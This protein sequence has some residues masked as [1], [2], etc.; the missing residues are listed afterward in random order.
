MSLKDKIKKNRW[1]MLFPRIFKAFRVYGFFIPLSKKIFEFGFFSKET[2]SFTYNLTAF[3]EKYII[4]S[5]ALV[6][7]KSVDEIETYFNEIKDDK[8]IQKYILDK[9]VVSEYK[10]FKDK[11]CD[12]G[13][14]MAWYALVRAIKPLVVVENGVEIGYTAALLCRAI[15]KNN[16]EGFNGSYYGFDINEKAGYLVKD[17]YF[18]D[19]VSFRYGDAINSILEFTQKINFYFSDG[20]RTPEYEHKEFNALLSHLSANAIIASNKMAFSTELA[21]FSQLNDRKFIYFKEEPKHWYPGS[22]LGISFV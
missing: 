13:S 19:I 6:T 15:Q 22:G 3:N 11:R 7:H 1:I 12:F 4:H 20:A 18:D 5:I 9:L 21:S 8:V 10:N 14:R 2:S 17:A 16:E